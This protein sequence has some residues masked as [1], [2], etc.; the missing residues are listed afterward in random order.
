MTHL[1]C[2]IFRRLSLRPTQEE[3]EQRNILHSKFS[4]ALVI[5][6]D[7]FF[8]N[9]FFFSQYL[10]LLSAQSIDQ[11]EKDK[12]EKKRYL[13]RK[14]STNPLNTLVWLYTGTRVSA[15]TLIIITEYVIITDNWLL[16]LISQNNV[17]LW[18]VLI[19][20]EWLWGNFNIAEVLLNTCISLKY[21]IIKH[22]DCNMH[23][24]LPVK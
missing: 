7:I 24:V 4:R 12:E 22:V 21:Y 3:L 1:H 8:F 9:N 14:V 10:F 5:F 2:S 6:T 16:Y 18:H 23:Q 11:A 13:I 20:F 17:I 19:P 15:F